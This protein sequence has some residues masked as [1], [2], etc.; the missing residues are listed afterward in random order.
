M[1]EILHRY[2]ALDR[3][4][5]IQPAFEALRGAVDEIF[6]IDETDV[7]RARALILGLTGLS[8][9]DALHAAV[10]EHHDIDR[11]M[12]FDQGFDAVPGVSRFRG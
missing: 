8:A 9:R 6:P 3:R 2:G 10:M 5:A 11:I 12:T 7:E 1:Q 4:D